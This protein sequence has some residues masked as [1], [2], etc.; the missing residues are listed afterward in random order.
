L[1]QHE[2]DVILDHYQLLHGMSPL[3]SGGYGGAC[4]R[5]L[6]ELNIIEQEKI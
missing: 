6:F 3:G 4:T 1:L 2:I 5:D